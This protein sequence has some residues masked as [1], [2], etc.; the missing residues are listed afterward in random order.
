MCRYGCQESTPQLMVANVRPEV[1]GRARRLQPGTRMDNAVLPDCSMCRVRGRSCFNLL[2]SAPL[3]EAW[4][5]TCE[6]FLECL[7]R[8]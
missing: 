7:H 5:V 4:G 3:G 1:S 2:T 8:A 6:L